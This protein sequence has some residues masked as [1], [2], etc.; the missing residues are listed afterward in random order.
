MSCLLLPLVDAAGSPARRFGS[1]NAPGWTR[2]LLP[3]SGDHP[4]LTGLGL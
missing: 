4:G 1:V 2:N 3:S